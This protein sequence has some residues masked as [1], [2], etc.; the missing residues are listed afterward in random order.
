MLQDIRKS[1]QGT[2]A[3]IIIGLI[4][5]SFAGFGLQS[6]LLDG[7]G[8]VVAEVNGEEI[9]P[10]ELQQAEYIHTR[11][12]VSMLG[13]NLDPAFLQEDRV[14]AQALE[15]LVGQKV[16]VQAATEAGL[17][18]AD[19]DL[20][21]VMMQI[22]DFQVDGQFNE[23][24]YKQVLADNGYTPATFRRNFAADLLVT[25]LRSGLAATDF[26]TDAE[27]ELSAAVLSE[28]RDFRYLTIPGDAFAESVQVSEAELEAYYDEHQ[29]EFL[30]D[31]SLD[32]DYITVS[33]DDFREPVDEEQVREAYELALQ[34]DQTGDEHRLSHILFVEG[35]DTSVAERVAAAQ[36]KLAEG[37]PFTD[38]A[39]EFSDDPGSASRGGDLGY[40]SG[41][42]FPEEI[43]EA[44]VGLTVGAVSAPLES[45]AGTHLLLLTER[46]EAT[47]PTFEELRAGLE[48]SLQQAE[49]RDQLLQTVELLKDLA[50]NAE[51]L[52][53][54]S[55]DLDLPIHDAPGVTRVLGEGVFESAALRNAAFSEDVLV[56]GNNSDVIE[57]AP[58]QYVVLSVREHHEAEVK[59]LEAVRDE[60]SY[61]LEQAAVERALAAEAKSL[62]DELRGGA[63][64]SA[65]AAEKGYSWQAELGFHRAQSGGSPELLARVFSLP[66]PT[67]GEVSDYL[68]AGSGDA[69]VIQLTRVREGVMDEL[70]EEEVNALRTGVAG[71]SGAL[72]DSEFQQS[73]RQNADVVIL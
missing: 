31:E 19:A 51:D 32:L 59:P 8:G 2:A 45:E 18:V 20:A 14:R 64:M 43:E 26:A 66:A 5:I 29:G 46:R 57:V 60:V 69:I 62:L 27:L 24:L 54:P 71:E 33:L 42:A 16:L 28:T 55:E 25:Q 13:D 49:A 11:R 61:I 38:V 68:L 52:Q 44:I 6:I 40:T 17:I 3:K 9:S 70:S 65:L 41:D 36:A 63:V 72:L 23:E 34:E 37:I 50:F 48:E 4:V 12:L 56:A 1:S 7:G 58:E 15:G 67:E 47:P 35:G 21:A 22:E 73:R 53:L 30:T 39:S 10:Q